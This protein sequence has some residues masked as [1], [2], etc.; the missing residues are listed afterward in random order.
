MVVGLL[1]LIII[2]SAVVNHFVHVINFLVHIFV[3]QVTTF[4]AVVIQQFVAVALIIVV[5]G[6]EREWGGGR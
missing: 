2:L 6:Q 5:V 3:I 4:D 1:D